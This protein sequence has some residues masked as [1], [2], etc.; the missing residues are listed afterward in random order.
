MEL[1]DDRSGQMLLPR[2]TTLVSNFNEK[3]TQ[4]VMYKGPGSEQIGHFNVDQSK[5]MH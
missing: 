5:G 4:G 3:N 1:Y 2:Y